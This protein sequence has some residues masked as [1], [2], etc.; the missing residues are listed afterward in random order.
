MSPIKIVDRWKYDYLNVTGKIEIVPV[1]W[2]E[3]F[4][5]E[6]NDPTTTDTEGRIVDLDGLAEHITREGLH[7]AGVIEINRTTKHARLIA[8]NHRIQVLD[9]VHFPVYN[10][11]KDKFTD[12][13]GDGIDQSENLTSLIDRTV[14]E[15]VEPPSKVF[16]DVQKMAYS[17][18]L[19]QS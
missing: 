18:M 5:L 1:S 8:G 2:L 17:N 3:K 9:M 16:L 7:H 4:M 6:D 15:V 11:F 10:I 14:G 13:L 19:P 12:S